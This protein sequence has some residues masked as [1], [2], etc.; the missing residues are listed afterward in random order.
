MK[1]RASLGERLG[2]LLAAAGCCL[3]LCC[4]RAADNPD[5]L[6]SDLQ[7]LGEEWQA[8]SAHA[9][10][11]TDPGD[12]ERICGRVNAWLDR[13]DRT[14]QAIL[15]NLQDRGDSPTELR[16][17]QRHVSLRMRAAAAAVRREACER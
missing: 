15:D 17:R 1:V 6:L 2:L 10:T 12:L 11:A 9:A 13:F 16:E 8:L 4:S 5:Q 7:A 3:V 14:D